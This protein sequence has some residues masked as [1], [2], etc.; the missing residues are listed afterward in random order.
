MKTNFKK[1]ALQAGVSAALAAG[2]MAAS[3]EITSVPAPA[4]LV[5]LFYYNTAGV[6]TKVR[7]TVPK[8]VGSDTVI[9]ILSGEAYG[10]DNIPAS[11]K[12]NV[13]S[14]GLAGSPAVH[15]FW[16]DYKSNE[17]LDGTIKV[18]PDDE[19][20]ISAEAAAAAASSVATVPTS[21][22][23]GYLILVNESASL[24][25]A[26]TFQFAADAWVENTN[27]SVSLPTQVSIPVYALADDV[28]NTTF[29]TPANNVIE[30]NG[31]PD[32]SP[33][34]TAIRTSSTN[35]EFN[36]RVVDVPLFK[37]NELATHTYE[38]LNTLVVWSDRNGADSLDFKTDNQP[39]YFV[40]S[41]ENQQS[42]PG[43]DMP[44]EL[45]FLQVGWKNG[46]SFG[47]NTYNLSTVL[48]VADTYAATSLNAVS[49]QASYGTFEDKSGGFLKLVLQNEQV[50]AGAVLD[51]AYSSVVI[52]N[53]PVAVGTGGQNPGTTDAVD[54]GFFTSAQ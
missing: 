7:I 18:T 46:Y 44:N 45:N 5:P 42:V 11:T 17:L 41:D 38:Y 29:P 50:P 23:A 24:G 33:I 14:A 43:K 19:E 31:A 8:S 39:F 40:D 47:G 6:D 10:V 2:S 53:V 20:F 9:G 25:G 54:T 1:I 48:G 35:P 22:Q 52:F 15:W 13:A 49:A 34:H 12:W 51:G 27:T 37:N 3:A 30:N 32:A 16:M 21:G 28:D 36:V 4:Q 26:P